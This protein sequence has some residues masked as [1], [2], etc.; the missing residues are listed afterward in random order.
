MERESEREKESRHGGSVTGPDVQRHFRL[1]HSSV[2]YKARLLQMPDSQLCLCTHTRSLSP[3]E[4]L[5]HRSPSHVFSGLR[6]LS[7]SLSSSLSHCKWKISNT[8]LSIAERCSLVMQ[9]EKNLQPFSPLFLWRPLH[10]S[11]GMGRE[12]ESRERGGDDGRRA[13]SCARVRVLVTVSAA[14]AC[15]ALPACSCKS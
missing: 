14:A 8:G 15:L 7:L 13:T 11:E 6:T 1:S 5:V 12:R 2:A 4:H 3:L 9:E 10:E